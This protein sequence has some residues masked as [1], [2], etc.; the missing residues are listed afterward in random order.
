M[1]LVYPE[2]YI[3]PVN[4]REIS[5]FDFVDENDA[6]G[7]YRYRTFRSNRYIDIF[8]EIDDEYS[9]KASGNK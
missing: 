3:Y 6:E 9:N 4:M 1:N 5:K 8:A 2:E 7:D